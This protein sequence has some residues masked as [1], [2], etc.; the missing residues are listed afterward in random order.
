MI[1][2]PPAPDSKKKKTLNPAAA[3]ATAAHLKADEAVN[4]QRSSN[5][6]LLRQSKPN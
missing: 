3:T 6:H 4:A 5:V 1:T 2:G